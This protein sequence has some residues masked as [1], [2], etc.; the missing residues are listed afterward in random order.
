MLLAFA[1]LLPLGVGLVAPSG[2]LA[3]EK[4]SLS[5]MRARELANED[6]CG[7][8]L[9]VLD[10]AKAEAPDDSTLWLLRGQ[11]QL[12]LQRYGESAES[13]ERAVT[14]EPESAPGHLFLGIARFHEGDLE[15][16]EREL[17]RAR[18]LGAE[19]AQLEFYSGLVLAQRA[20]H[21]EGALAL[22]RARTSDSSLVEPAA[23]YYAGMAWQRT[24]ERE[25]AIESLERVVN[26]YPGTV[27]AKEAAVEL[28]R[29]REPVGRAWASITAGIEYDSNVV[30]LGDNEPLPGGISDEDDF[31]GVWFVQGGVEAFRTENW[32]GGAL[33]AYSG[34]AQFELTEYDTQYPVFSLWLDR[35]IDDEA[36]VRLR[37]D[38]G[39][40]WVDNDPFLF[41]QVVDLAG[42]KDFGSI[43]ETGLGLHFYWDNYLFSAR[44]SNGSP[45][46]RLDQ[47]ALGLSP[48]IEHRIPLDFADTWLRGRYSYTHQWGNGQDWDFD[49]HEFNLGFETSLPWQVRFDASG[50]YIYEPFEHPS[51]FSN[52][53]ENGPDRE[54]NIWIGR[55]IL[56]RAFWERWV[57]SAEY[58]YTDNRSNVDAYDYDRHIVGLYFTVRLP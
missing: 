54:D 22:E 20:E 28:E 38:T 51:F 26:E 1:L 25:R 23:S 14:L 35:E 39:Y 58:T 12:R 24:E 8:A 5:I 9:T 10:A 27:W 50:T 11:C 55:A 49:A 6:R 41:Q 42:Y 17:D 3:D 29:A 31:R 47:D 48:R 46:D 7:E 15:A 45:I 33:A 44:K 2:A 32:S 52:D 16:A 34:T 18:E 30:Q 13:L 53:P 43:G 4:T 56:S 21:R 57:V 36:L 37:Y 40:A 19:G